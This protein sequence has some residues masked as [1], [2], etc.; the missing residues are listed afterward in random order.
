MK[1]IKYFGLVFFVIIIAISCEPI[2][3]EISNKPTIPEN[4]E[5]D[6]P[7]IVK[8]EEPEFVQGNLPYFPAIAFHI[9][10]R[11]YEFRKNDEGFNFTYLEY[12]EE[13]LLQLYPESA[14]VGMMNVAQVQTDLN[15][16]N[17]NIYHYCPIKIQNY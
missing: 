5:S 16:T 7:P 12:V 3:N 14:Y 8:P 4:Q 13:R 1:L 17:Y 2:D 11:E 9:I 6:P 10:E 15:M